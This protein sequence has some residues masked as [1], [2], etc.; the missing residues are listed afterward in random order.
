VTVRPPEYLRFCE[1]LHPLL[2]S[3]SP[4]HGARL[5][6]A[7]YLFVSH[8]AESRHPQY[9]RGEMTYGET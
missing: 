9:G 5:E 2:E 6:E 1:R 4:D 7:R 8:P 3:L